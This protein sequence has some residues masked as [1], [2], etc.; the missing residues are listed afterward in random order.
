MSKGTEGGD[1]L[2]ESFA[3]CDGNGD[4][5]I[6]FLEFVTLLTN[7]DAGMTEQEMWVGFQAIDTDNDQRIDFD[8]FAAWWRDT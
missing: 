5:A 3:A 7:L 2:A 8:E 6:E 4:G 1:E